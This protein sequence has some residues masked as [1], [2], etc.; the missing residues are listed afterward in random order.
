MNIFVHDIEREVSYIGNIG[1]K[2]LDFVYIHVSLFYLVQLPSRLAH[3]LCVEVL[4]LHFLILSHAHSFRDPKTTPWFTDFLEGL[5]NL[6]NSFHSWL[7]FITVNECKPGSIKEKDTC[8]HIWGDRCEL[9]EILPD[10]VVQ[11]IFLPLAVNCRN[12]CE[13]LYVQGKFIGA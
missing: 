12:T 2:W 1:V 6:R 8:G 10:G 9:P 5:K 4:S 13:V 7:W 3:Q 11:E